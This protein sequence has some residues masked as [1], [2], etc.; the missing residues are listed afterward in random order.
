MKTLLHIFFLLITCNT[1]FSQSDI[2]EPKLKTNSVFKCYPNPVET[3]L[4]IIG[5]NK[6]KTIEF[7]DVL[8]NRVAIYL[9]NKSIIK[10]D[11]SFLKSGIYLIQVIDENHKVETNKLVVK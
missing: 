7:I 2:K 10:L 6:I 8:G 11:V 5:I 1:L 9:F 3:D 4:F